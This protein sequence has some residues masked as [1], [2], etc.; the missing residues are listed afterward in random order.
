MTTIAKNHQKLVSNTILNE[1]KIFQ[2][3]YFANHLAFSLKAKKKKLEEEVKL[4]QFSKNREKITLKTI[5]NAV[6][7]H[8]D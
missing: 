6:N 4:P 3:F 2:N 8:F 1:T 5:A 7:F